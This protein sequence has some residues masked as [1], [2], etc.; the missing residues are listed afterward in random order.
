M[1][2]LEYLVI[3]SIDSKFNA[4]LHY[5]IQYTMLSSTQFYVQYKDQPQYKV[6]ISVAYNYYYTMLSSEDSN[7]QYTS[8]IVISAHSM[9]SIDSNYDYAQSCLSLQYYIQ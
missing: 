6:C 8:L 7:L 5:I 9:F 1:T 2:A 3:S 4:Q